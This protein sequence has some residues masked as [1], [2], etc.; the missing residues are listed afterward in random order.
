M[1][2]QD[3]AQRPAS[4]C[5]QGELQRQR[6]QGRPTLRV[7]L[8][9]IAPTVDGKLDDWAGAAWATID[10]SG[11]A[12]F[13]DSHSKP[14]DV[15]ATVA[16]AGDRLYAAFRTG[17]PNLLLNSGET[18]LAPF[19]SGGGLDLMI[20]SRPACRRRPAKPRAGRPAAA[21]DAGP[22]ETA[23]ADLSARRA[24]DER[25]RCPSPRLGG[26]SRSIAWTT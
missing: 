6:E 16:V 23:G 24:G 20:G 17:D 21:G 10:K 11:V 9:K 25:A 14:Y 3:L 19:K 4:I 7:P 26:R 18:P 2:P 5:S 1:G 13:F 8:R 22:G 15:T 12:A